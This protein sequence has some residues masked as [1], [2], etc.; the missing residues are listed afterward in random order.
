M[1]FTLF[2]LFA[3]SVVANTAC[4]KEVAVEDGS[5]VQYNMT[6]VTGANTT[7][8]NEPVLLTVSYRYLNGCQVVD[9][10]KQETTGNV[11][12]IKAFGNFDK[13]ALCTQDVGTRSKTYTFTSS[14]RGT[15]ELRFTNIDNSF[16]SHTITVN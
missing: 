16:I 9:T 13:T 6:S 15:F 11:L 4:K 10:F 2:L 14:S 7:T 3:L 12:S 5:L 8:V 1:K